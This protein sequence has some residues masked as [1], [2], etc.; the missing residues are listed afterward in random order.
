MT[1]SL[2]TKVVEIVVVAFVAFIPLALVL[3]CLLQ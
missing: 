2:K 3:F 1:Y